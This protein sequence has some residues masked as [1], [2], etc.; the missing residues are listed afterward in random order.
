MKTIDVRAAV[1]GRGDVNQ[2]RREAAG[3]RVM[4]PCNT[5]SRIMRGNVFADGFS[6]G[7]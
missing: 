4:A 3:F 7:K 2:L 6:K 1:T 5:Y